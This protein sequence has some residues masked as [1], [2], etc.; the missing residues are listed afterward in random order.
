MKRKNS[1]IVVCVTM[2][3]F[4]TALPA[5]RAATKVGRYAV[6]LEN[7]RIAV[8][9]LDPTTGQLRITQSVAASSYSS[10]TVHPNNKFVYAPTGSNSIAGF[11]ISS[12]G[13]LTPPS[14]SPFATAYAWQ[15]I[16]FT[17]T[18]KFGYTQSYLSSNSEIFS[19][20]TTRGL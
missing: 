14:G 13:L 4:F 15:G 9:A 20:N 1:L 10:L 5:A 19:V 3:V 16:Y 7:S 6:A 12:T 11:A 2:L 8:Y 17:P 18:G